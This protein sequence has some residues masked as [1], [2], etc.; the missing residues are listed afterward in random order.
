MAT[1]MGIAVDQ[2]IS[3]RG[4]KLEYNGLQQNKIERMQIHML[5]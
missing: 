4:C 3:Y 1:A 2:E 5:K